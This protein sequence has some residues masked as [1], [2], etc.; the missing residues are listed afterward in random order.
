[1]DT[2]SWLRLAAFGLLALNCFEQ[3]LRSAVPQQPAGTVET[4]RMATEPFSFAPPESSS[5]LANSGDRSPLE[6]FSPSPFPTL[7]SG[8]AQKRSVRFAIDERFV[9]AV[10][11]PMLSKDLSADRV[12]RTWITS[13]L[14]ADDGGVSDFSRP[15]TQKQRS[16]APSHEKVGKPLDRIRRTWAPVAMNEREKSTSVELQTRDLSAIRGPSCVFDTGGVLSECSR[17]SKQERPVASVIEESPPLV[18]W[19][20]KLRA[21]EKLQKPKPEKK[22][23][24][25]S[26]KRKVQKVAVSPQSSKRPQSIWG[27][28]GEKWPPSP[29][30]KPSTGKSSLL[31][32]LAR[33]L[34]LPRQG[35]N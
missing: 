23:K 18:T 31:R 3:L 28:T 14:H 6:D 7:Q 26:V 19:K 24:V 2:T 27:S 16:A 22:P 20:P 11:R 12:R 34:P 35:P 4:A 8:Q 25:A 13:G 17:P 21:A 10:S 5:K 33:L 30:I 32:R 1:M 29:L 15:S 9:H